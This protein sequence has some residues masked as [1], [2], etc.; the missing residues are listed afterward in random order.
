MEELISSSTKKNWEKLGVTESDKKLCSRANK[1]LSQKRIM[2]LEYFSKK[3][4]KNDIIVLLEKI[5]QLNCTIEEVIYSLAINLLKRHCL[6]E[7]KHVKIILKQ[8]CCTMIEQLVEYPLPTNEQD[9][10]GLIY[11]CLQKE[12]EKNKKGAYYTPLSVVEKMLKEISLQ[13][14]QTF[15][16]PCCGSGAFLLAVKKAQC[17]QLFGI[18]KDPLAVFIAKCNLVLK[19]PNEIFQPQIYLEDYL[20]KEITA[21]PRQFDFI[22]TNPPWGALKEKEIFAMKETFSCFLIKA[23]EQLKE[24]GILHFL[25]PEAVMNVK[26]HRKLREFLLC[27]GNLKKIEYYNDMFS[28]VTTKFVSVLLEKT[29]SQNCISIKKE[30]KKV[31]IAPKEF[32]KTK[33]II[34][35]FYTPQESDLLKKIQKKGAYT[36]SHS[37]WALGI[38]TGNNKEKLYTNPKKGMEKIYTGKE[39]KPY[40]LEPARHYIFY[41][42]QAL[43]QTAKEEYYRAKEKLVYKFISKKLVFAYDNTGSLFLNSANILIPSI[44]NMSIKTVMA[45]LN[46]PLYQFLYMCLFGEVKILKGNLLQ[47]PFPAISEQENKWITEIAEDILKGKNQQKQIIDEMVYDIFGLE[48]K[49]K[50]YIKKYFAEKKT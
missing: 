36:L 42:R 38:V 8:Y 50:E 6:A 23:Y 12:G 17:Y 49:E 24:N 29:K 7:K 18:D 47:L 33:N 41:Q 15:L 21:L 48:Q 22:V 9:L 46:T 39:I 43:Q 3:E 2:P 25:L 4:N 28:G 14:G 44:P 26:A 27:H 1:M 16:D 13:K 11:Q 37:K 45:F 35:H 34:F 10:L 20:K 5:T 31:E 40:F 19:F 32:Y 30:E